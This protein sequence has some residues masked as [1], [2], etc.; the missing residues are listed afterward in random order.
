MTIENDDMEDG[1]FK[2]FLMSAFK[3]LYDALKPG[4]AFYVWYASREHLNFE[5]SLRENDLP[6][7]QQLFWEK[8]A[9]VLGRS[10]YQWMHEPCLYGWKEGASHYFVDDRTKTTVLKYNKPRKNE[11]HPTMK[12]I[13][14]F[15]ELIQ[16]SSKLNE[17]VLDLFGG[18]GTT[19]ICCEQ[20]NR[21]CYMM[22]YDP[23]YADVIIARWE[24]LTG[25]K[26]ELV[27]E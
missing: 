20:L 23:I 21:Q 18:S 17:K 22:E 2:D 25:K 27:Q 1:A 19:L 4:G 16:N 8:N 15:G 6:V 13:G 24:L 14:L 11:F 26:A 10:D 7:R 9:L 5:S 3:N 12:P